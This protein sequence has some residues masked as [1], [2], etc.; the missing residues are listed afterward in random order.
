MD[1]ERKKT[2]ILEMTNPEDLCPKRADFPDLRVERMETPCPEFNKFLHTMVGF[3]YRWGGRTEWGK[4]RWY[5][6]ADRDEMETWVAYLG[7]TPAG[8]YELER[9]SD[10]SVQIVT[11]GLLSQFIGRGLGGHLLTCAVERAWEMGADKVW[12][13]TCSHDHPYALENYQARGLRVRET[14]EGPANR[15]IKSF[16]ELVE[17]A[18]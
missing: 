15:P 4:D 3:D 17:A 10:G 7:G 2:Y 13:S 16:W 18:R 12:L 14:R 9:Q 8:Y 1:T 5:A 11:F 6:H